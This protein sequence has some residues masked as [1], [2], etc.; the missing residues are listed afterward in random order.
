MLIPKN[1]PIR[2]QKLRDSAN[3]A[4]CT[5]NSLVCNHNPETSVLAHYRS[6]GTNSG[7]GIKPDDTA[8]AIAC[9]AC[10]DLLDGRSN[11]Y[12]ANSKDIKDLWLKGII[13]T[14]RYWVEEGIL[15]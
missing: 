4:E 9:S 10:H 5:I 12:Q 1:K 13:A 6:H 2:I 3:G 11:T 8:A 15:K 14:Y 7:M